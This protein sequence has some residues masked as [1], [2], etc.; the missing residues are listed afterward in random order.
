M[1]LTEHAD[2]R[3]LA[4]TTSSYR[5]LLWVFCIAAFVSV[6]VSDVAASGFLIFEQGIN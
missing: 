2:Q 1:A 3:R 4:M 5:P 6:L